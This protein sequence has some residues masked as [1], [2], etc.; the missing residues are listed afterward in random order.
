MIVIW[1]FAIKWD[2]IKVGDHMVSKIKIRIPDIFYVVLYTIDRLH[3][4]QK[5][6]MN[7]LEQFNDIDTDLYG[8]I[9]FPS[10]RK[11]RIH[12][13]YTICFKHKE[14]LAID[15]TYLA[16][17]LDFLRPV[18]N[19]SFSNSLYIEFETAEPI[20]KTHLERFSKK[21]FKQIIIIC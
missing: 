21:R 14:W 18:Y 8:I 4:F 9:C 7:K 3:I 5:L 10:T 11:Y 17:N 6:S 19:I 20:V 16:C 2:F 13:L 12:T 15:S 1:Y